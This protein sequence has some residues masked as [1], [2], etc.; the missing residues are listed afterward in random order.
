MVGQA[1]S[2]GN[3]AIIITFSRSHFFQHVLRIHCI[4]LLHSS[5]GHHHNLVDIF[6]QL[7]SLLTVLCV[8]ILPSKFINK[9][10]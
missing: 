3:A 7:L 1:A 9:V 4:I 6:I 10:H 5:N 2:V 8:Q